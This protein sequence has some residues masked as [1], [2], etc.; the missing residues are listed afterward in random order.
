MAAGAGHLLIR[1]AAVLRDGGGALRPS[2]RVLAWLTWVAALQ[3]PGWRR[4][5]LLA[6][7]SAGGGRGG[8]RETAAAGARGIAYRGWGS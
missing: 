8:A 2:L 4:R 7:G 6:G 1:R 3:G 5:G